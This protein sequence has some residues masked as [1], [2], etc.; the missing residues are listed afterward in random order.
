M[1]QP[2]IG[3]FLTILMIIFT[4]CQKEGS[5][6]SKV[7]E[8]PRM[9]VTIGEALHTVDYG[10]HTIEK[11]RG[12]SVSV[13]TTDAASPNQIAQEFTPFIV[14]D[15]ENIEIS[16]E[17]DPEIEIFRWD[18]ATIIGKIENEGYS[19]PL[20]EKFGKIIIEVVAT[21]S[22]AEASYTFVVTR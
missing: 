10:G 5:G 7:E 13:E 16:L 2:Q 18:G 14:N 17:G 12:A 22:N 6:S 11:R 15:A 8:I 21:W 3:I 20:P 19:F 9:K 4:G 1:F